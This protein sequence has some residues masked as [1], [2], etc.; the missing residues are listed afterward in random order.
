MIYKSLAIN[1]NIKNQEKKN[2]DVREIYLNKT[3][4]R[5]LPYVSLIRESD[6]DKIKING[7][8]I[9]NKMKDSTGFL[10]KIFDLIKVEKFTLIH[11]D[12]TCSNMLWD[13]ETKK[14]S[15]FDP[16][17][18][19]GNTP[20]VGDPAYDW[21]KLYY[22]IVDNYDLTNIQNITIQKNDLGWEIFEK[23]IDMESYFW[24]ECPFSRDQ[25][26]IRVALI[27]FSLIGY[28]KN[29]IEVMNL[30]FLKGNLI[31]KELDEL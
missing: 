29:D 7:K 6:K 3:L 20:L 22:S 9:E 31:L 21:A 2:A 13:T 17:G 10:N 24:E 23:N 1:S 30:A 19:F 5:Y 15:I 27:W 16:R 18:M 12:V 26:L 11:G 14:I 28:A 8:I 25:I 4:S